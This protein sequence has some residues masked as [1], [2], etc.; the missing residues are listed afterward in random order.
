MQVEK[1]I[2][3][4]AHMTAAEAAAASSH[5]LRRVPF[6]VTRHFA[7]PRGSTPFARFGARFIR[8]SL[9]RQISVSQFV[10]ASIGEPSTVVLNGVPVADRTSARDPVVLMAQRLEPEKQ[11]E[12]AIEAW[13]RSSLR[14]RG[15][16]MVVAGSGRQ[17]ADLLERITQQNLGGSVTLLG[18][19]NDTASLMGRSS[20]FLAT[21]PVDSF[22]FSVVEAMAAGV[23]VVAAR[24]GAHTETAGS[25]SDQWLFSP[26]NAS[27]AASM[28]DALGDDPEMRVGYG[29]QLRA[30]QRQHLS[31]DVHVDQL[32]MIY[33]DLA[34]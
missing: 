20:I 6:V 27:Q 12:V 30:A 10:A 22:G 32:E 16:R 1:P 17:Q 7:A 23:P 29:N 3:V 8:A 26:G 25:V 13:A 14:H 24:G 21:S 19:R 2:L 33:K 15:W 5:V 34:K 31:L 11:T 9:A 4:H 18:M 28:L